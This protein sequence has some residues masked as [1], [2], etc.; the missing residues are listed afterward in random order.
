MSKI[1]FAAAL[2]MILQVTAGCVQ[3]PTERQGVS[4]LRPQISFVADEQLNDA[5][6]LIDKVD[7]GRVGDFIDGEAALRVLPGSHLVTVV[8]PRGVVLQERFY[9]ADGVSKSFILR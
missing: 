7:V 6:V 2:I 8:A 4:D 9:V 5:R 3:M 1:L